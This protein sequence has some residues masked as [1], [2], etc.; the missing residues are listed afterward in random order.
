MNPLDLTRIN[1]LAPYKVWT[2]DECDYFIEINRG[3]IF[4]TG[5]MDDYSIWPMGAYQFTINE[6][7]SISKT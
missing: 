3:Q 6:T 7:I 5:F 1:C 4:V 2:E